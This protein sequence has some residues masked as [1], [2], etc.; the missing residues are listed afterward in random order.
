VSVGVLRPA[1]ALGP[2]AALAA[3]AC[4]VAATAVGVSAAA[5]PSLTT[6]AVLGLA[7]VW[8][9]R[10]SPA[11]PLGCIGLPTLVIAL[12]GRDPF[13][14]GTV[15][16][17]MFAWTM[18]SVAFFVRRH[19]LAGGSLFNVPVVA[20][21]LIGVVLLLGT[22]HSPDPSYGWFKTEDF[23]A[24]NLAA[25]TAA[26]CIA[27]RRDDLDLF[28]L[29]TLVVAV[30]AALVL[31]HGLHAGGLNSSVGGRYSIAVDEHPIELG[32]DAATGILLALYLGAAA[33]RRVVRVLALATLPILAIALFAAGSRG[34]VLGLAASAVVFFALAAR[35]RVARRRISFVALGVAAS[36]VV[37]PRVVP[38]NDLARGLQILVNG[39]GAS[40][41]G[42]GQLWSEAATVFGNHTLVG[43]GTGGF[44]YLEPIQRYPHNLVLE[45][46]VETGI[47]GAGLVLWAIAVAY[48]K[49]FATWRHASDDRARLASALVVA[50]LTGAVVNACVSGD[51]PV[52][53]AVWIGLGLACGGWAAAHG[54][55]R[56]VR[57]G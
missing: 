51:L 43:I 54:R 2:S 55:D 31:L 49:S 41:N 48:Q 28:A 11:V 52:N 14:A 21:V 23:A 20:S 25:M 40:S 47:L 24:V 7:G 19:G 10:I 38:H 34:P 39:L 16:A 22:F 50:F 26:I 45:L 29:L 37:V 56:M 8:L 15:R 44:A 27:H 17:A 6:I 57:H 5:R 46:A 18:L 3:G 32:R 4:I 12:V 42:R 53:G 9:A 35:T 30:A 13:G 33:R 1:R 36:S